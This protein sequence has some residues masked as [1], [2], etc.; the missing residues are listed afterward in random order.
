MLRLYLWFI[1]IAASPASPT[2]VFCIVG[3]DPDLRGELLASSAK[4]TLSVR[5]RRRFG[6]KRQNQRDV[7]MLRL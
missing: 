7:V 4:E 2:R 6:A 3:W 1:L 5:A